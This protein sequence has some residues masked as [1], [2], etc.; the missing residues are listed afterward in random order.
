MFYIT[1]Y[2]RGTIHHKTTTRRTTRRTTARV[3]TVYRGLHT[4]GLTAHRGDCAPGG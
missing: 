4:E 2:M 3:T 1:D